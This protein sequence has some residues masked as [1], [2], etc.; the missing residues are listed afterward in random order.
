MRRVGLEAQLLLF[1]SKND[2]DTSPKL[3]ESLDAEG[4]VTLPESYPQS[5]TCPVPTAPC[6]P[7]RSHGYLQDICSAP[8]VCQALGIQWCVR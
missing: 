8:T 1:I 3:S 6:S 5:R 4:D 2:L 7:R